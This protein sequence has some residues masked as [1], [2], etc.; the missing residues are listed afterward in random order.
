MEDPFKPKQAT[1]ARWA[2]IPTL[3]IGATLLAMLALAVS[4]VSMARTKA[5]KCLTRPGPTLHMA[6]DQL[7][8]AHWPESGHMAP[9]RS[10]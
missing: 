9:S 5:C 3:A 7:Q 10:M 8:P 6:G 1:R 2:L 4:F